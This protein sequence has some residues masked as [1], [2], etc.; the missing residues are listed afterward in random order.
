MGRWRQCPK[1]HGVKRIPCP[2]C[3]GRG[4]RDEG[5]NCLTCQSVR[6][7]RGTGRVECDVCDGRG[8]VWDD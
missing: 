4:T 2:A 3:R 5:E 7:G 1:C 8:R 6:G